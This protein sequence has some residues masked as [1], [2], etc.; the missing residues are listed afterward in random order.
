MKRILL[1]LT[2]ASATLFSLSDACEAKSLFEVKIGGEIHLRPRG[3]GRMDMSVRPSSKDQVKNPEFSGTIT[4]KT[5]IIIIGK[6]VDGKKLILLN[7][8]RV[9]VY[10]KFLKIGQ[11]Q[12]ARAI[13]LYLL[14]YVQ[15]PIS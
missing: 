12:K 6:K 2:V 1:I 3:D 7:G 4:H 10:G 5:K 9:V 11:G 14:L 15:P 8:K 13:C